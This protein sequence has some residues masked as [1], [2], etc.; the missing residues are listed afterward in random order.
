MNFISLTSEEKSD[1]LNNS[2]LIFEDI[3]YFFLMEINLVEKK[4]LIYLEKINKL[5][6]KKWSKKKSLEEISTIITEKLF[7]NENKKNFFGLL[8]F[9]V[10]SLNFNFLIEY[11]LKDLIHG[12]NSIDFL[13]GNISKK[14]NLD[15]YIVSKGVRSFLKNKLSISYCNEPKLNFDN[16]LFF[17][18]NNI[19]KNIEEQTFSLNELNVYGIKVE[20]YD[21]FKF[22]LLNKNVSPYDLFGF[23]SFNDN[24]EKFS[25]TLRKIKSND[26]LNFLIDNNLWVDKYYSLTDNIF[27]LWDNFQTNEENLLKLFNHLKE[28][29]LADNLCVN[30]FLSFFGSDFFNKNKTITLINECLKEDVSSKY[31]FCKVEK[32]ELMMKKPCFI[33]KKSNEKINAIIFLENELITLQKNILNSTL[34]KNVNSKKITI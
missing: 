27:I 29:V 25:E 10:N 19:N 9:F 17:V 6:S 7:D 12:L 18:E 22:L 31:E 30:V 24:F 5:L 3:I 33:I 11:K 2:K 23:F 4:D 32:I 34:K 13:L 26:F 1:I 14:N 20:C 28:K 15:L 8:I 21:F 16:A